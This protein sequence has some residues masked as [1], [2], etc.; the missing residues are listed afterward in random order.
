[1]LFRGGARGFRTHRGDGQYYTTVTGVRVYSVGFV[2]Y[3]VT[4]I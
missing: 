2:R 4:L 3:T 1:M